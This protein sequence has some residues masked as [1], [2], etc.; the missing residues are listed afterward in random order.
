MSNKRDEDQGDEGKSQGR[1]QGGVNEEDVTAMSEE[2][3][4]K[5][6][7]LN[8]EKEFLTQKGQKPLTR[9]YFAVPLN[10]NDQFTYFK[11][12][13]K[14]LF[15][16]NNVQGG[17]VT[18]YDDPLT[19]ASN[20]QLEMK[21]IGLETD[22]PPIK[23]KAGYGDQVCSI[24]LLLINNAMKTKKFSFKS[25]KF[26]T[27][28]YEEEPEMGIEG[29]DENME[30]GE[31]IIPSDDED[32][33][34]EHG[35]KKT[36]QE[37]FPERQMIESAID[38]KEWILEVERVAPKLKFTMQNEPKE[39]RNHMELS[40][41]YSDQVKKLLPDA[42]TKLEKQSDALS[43]I[44][45]KVQKRERSI[46][47][48]MTDL[49]TEYKAKAEELKKIATRYNELN[50]VVKE[51]GEQYKQIAEKLEQI[52]AKASEHGNNV[53]DSSPLMK[54]K[55]SI[56]KLRNE[57][58]GMDLRIGVL[59]HTVMQ[60]KFKEKKNRDDKNGLHQIEEMEIE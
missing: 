5:L 54:I 30:L 11:T 41:Q 47:T 33:G 40:K 53:T 10:P 50:K 56:Q 52:T 57:I 1:Q 23:L 48:N 18:K 13:V 45:E 43:K 44:L 51:M 34:D 49:G 42:R 6:R 39:W 29:N 17:D 25:P 59:A 4:D 12:L 55:S 28:T 35:E 60:H 22:I 9:A 58:K 26:E 27:R 20:I 46:N 32:E 7:L 16:L 38:S 19:V 2:I 8:Y 3:L 36:L 24:L 15:V 37:A 14:W 21:K 31:N